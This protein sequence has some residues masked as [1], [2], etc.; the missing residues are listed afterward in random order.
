MKTYGAIEAGGTKMVL[1]L[2]DEQGNILER[3]SIPTKTPAV[4]LPRMAD[5]F[6]GK[7]IAALGVGCFGPVDL[8]R[9]SPTY[10]SITETPKTAWRHTPIVPYLQ[11]EL[12]VPVGFDTDV[13]AAALAESRIG[14]AKGCASCL[15]V[16]VGTGV[17]GGVVIDGKTVHGLMHPEIGHQLLRPSENDPM[18]QGVCPYHPGCLEGL[19]AG[20]SIEKR[21]G[22]SAKLLPQEHPAWTL[23]AGY[24]AQLCHNAIMS[25]SPERIILGGG[26]MQQSFLFP[27]IRKQTAALL[28]GYVACL[29]D[30]ALDALIVPPGLDIHSG[31]LGSWMLGVDAEAGA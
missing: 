20:P 15:Y 29:D 21:W 25:F 26:V 10:G 31:L 30:A 3:L 23:E 14:A 28:N 12:G 27:L 1:G 9:K 6:R 5:F 13:N 11:K 16:T 17:G 24:L 18:P 2:L 8:N 19:A 4:T 7:G 22:I